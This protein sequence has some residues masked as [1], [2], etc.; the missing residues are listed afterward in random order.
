M[1]AGIKGTVIF[2]VI[3]RKDLMQHDKEEARKI[4]EVA[5]HKEVEMGRSCP[6]SV[7][8]IQPRGWGSFLF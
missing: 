1:G 7:L 3:T 5:V 4:K 6:H 2:S 8:H